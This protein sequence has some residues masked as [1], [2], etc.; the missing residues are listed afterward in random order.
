M[1]KNKKPR[2]HLKNKHTFFLR[3][4]T[5]QIF[6][7]YLTSPLKL[8]IFLFSWIIIIFIIT[9]SYWLI[10]SP[11]FRLSKIDCQQEISACPE[12]ILAYL[13]HF[14]ASLIWE[15]DTHQLSQQILAVTPQAQEVNINVHF[16]NTLIVSIKNTQPFVF[17][18]LPDQSEGLIINTRLKVIERHQNNYQRLPQI[19]INHTISSDISIGSS[20]SHQ[21]IAFTL[22]Y[23]KSL[24]SSGI[25]FTKAIVYSPD[26]IHIHL[27]NNKIALISSHQAFSRQLTTLQ[28]ILSKD[29]MTESHPVIDTRHSRPVLKR[30]ID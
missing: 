13:N 15:L 2:Q 26:D 27:A 18:T 3:K 20:I 7:Q 28:L 24:Q 30:S 12:Y 8:A 21:P 22:D 14:K 10:N 9:G 17:L 16:P 5:L 6:H 1:Y 11:L 29:T 25:G 4:S 23:L 19:I